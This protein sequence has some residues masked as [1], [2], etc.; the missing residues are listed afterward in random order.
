MVSFHAVPGLNGLLYALI[1]IGF[2]TLAPIGLIYTLTRYK[3]ISDPDLPDRRERFIPYLMVVGL[4]A[5]VYVIFISIHA[6]RQILAITASYIAVTSVGAIISLFWKI[7]MHL[8]G[9][10]GPITA[11]VFLVNPYFL[12]AYLLLIPLGWAR[13]TLKKHNLS[14]ILVGSGVS[15]AITLLAIFL[16]S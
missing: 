12:L 2:V 3:K 8:A 10:A 13:Y 5:V 9:V 6:P 7:S 14:Q 15:M 16:Y 4:Y 1:G 11:L